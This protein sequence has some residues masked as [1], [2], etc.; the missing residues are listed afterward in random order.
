[1]IACWRAWSSG[2]PASA[3]LAPRPRLRGRR[4]PAAGLGRRGAPGDRGPRSA[5]RCPQQGGEHDGHDHDEDGR[6]RDDPRPAPAASAVLRGDVVRGGVV[7]AGVAAV[8]RGDR[9]R[10]R[11]P[12]GGRDV[13]GLG[14]HHPV[15]HQRGRRTPA[16]TRRLGNPRGRG[17]RDGR[18]RG[19]PGA[20]ARSW[21]RTRRSLG[22]HEE[23]R[24]GP[25][26][27][28]GLG[29]DETGEVA[30]HPLHARAA[31]GVGPQQ[32]L[33]QRGDRAPRRRRGVLAGG[34]AVQDGE[35]V[36]ARAEG[37]HALE[38]ACRASS[39]ASRRPSGSRPSRPAPPRGRGRPGCRPSSRSR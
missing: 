13:G 7:R 3:L 15:R 39:P 34:D 35:G 22:T 4:A 6:H 27:G 20:R 11:R 29:G 19:R 8:L 5:A 36:V 12:R 25:F 30:A 14:G 31:R 10:R 2:P 33:D 28:P 21:P 24:H 37:R 17:G 32:V 9:C 23:R 1:M 16:G 18:G 38:R 26:F